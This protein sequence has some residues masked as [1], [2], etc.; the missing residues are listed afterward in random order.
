MVLPQYSKTLLIGSGFI[1][2][3][4]I[5]HTFL[6][7]KLFFLSERFRH[8][9]L[10]F[11]ESSKKYY[12]LSELIG[13]LSK[14][15]IVFFVWAIPLFFLFWISE[16]FKLTITYF[17]TRNYSFPIYIMTIVVLT[18][19]KPIIDFADRIL[20]FLAKL[21]PNTP[22]MW[23]WALLL[24]SP[25]IACLVKEPGAMIIG[26]TL[27]LRK[28]YYLTPSRS[29]RYATMGLLFSNISMGGLLTP[30]SSRAFMLVQSS[31]NWKPGFLLAQF[32]WKAFIAIILSTTI[33]YVIFRKEFDKLPS[34]VRDRINFKYAIPWWISA[35]HILFLAA[36]L[37]IKPA[38]VI[39]AA[40]FVLFLLFH[41]MTVFYQNPLHLD[42]MALLGLFYTGVLIHGDLQG[43]WISLIMEKLPGLGVLIVSFILSACMDNS[44]A[45]YL[46]MNVTSSSDCYR[47]LVVAGV[48]AA[49]GLTL[50]A[51]SANLLGYTVLKTSFL[52][53][54]FVKLFYYGL[55]PSLV[56]LTIFWF[57]RSV[58]GFS[59]CFF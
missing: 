5:I 24:G 2:L 11:T 45:H 31:L 35:T 52:S 6:T 3:L 42:K 16:G 13:I 23:W 36:I 18:T 33:Y 50:L 12:M 22:K 37:W 7:P 59:L 43:K 55:T 15:E 28:F 10:I 14:V 32:S 26:S 51:N 38:S 40:F 47:Y 53:I 34:T 29:F 20:T 1:F 9:Q 56:A 49:G 4:A 44:I 25:L 58:P 54:S 19:S 17:D 8:K 27:L 46:A 57:L 39:L 21:G 41:K 30:V 48:T